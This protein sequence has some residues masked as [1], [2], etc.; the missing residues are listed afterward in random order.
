MLRDRLI[1]TATTRTILSKC[2]Y[3]STKTISL[4]IKQIR[5]EQ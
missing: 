1:I 5:L 4:I 3:M 2:L